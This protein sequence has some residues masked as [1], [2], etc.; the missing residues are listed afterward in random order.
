MVCKLLRGKSLNKKILLETIKDLLVSTAIFIVGAFSLG[1]L[2][3]SYTKNTT[4][5]SESL[6]FKKEESVIEPF[7]PIDEV[8]IKLNEYKAQKRAELVEIELQAKA[9]R[10]E[11]IFRKYNSPMQGYGRLLV[12]ETER[13]GGDYKVI[14]AIAGNE[15][16]FGRIPYKL[17][18][19]FGYLNN[20]QYSGWEEAIRILSCRI[21]YQHLVPCQNNVSCV[22][23]K[24]AGPSDDKEK[25]VRNITWFVNQI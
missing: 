16:G 4:V 25:W 1:S 15:S 12:S 10:V 20:V 3:E 18:N 7:M 21:S 13:C 6:K 11:A 8:I 19:P 17:Y 23:I 14:T 22:V 5:Q 9:E 2:N 24:Y